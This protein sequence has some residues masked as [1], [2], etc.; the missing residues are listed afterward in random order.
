LFFRRWTRSHFACFD[1]LK[2]HARKPRLTGIV[3]AVNGAEIEKLVA[4]CVAL[5]GLR[6]RGLDRERQLATPISLG[7]WLMRRGFSA[8][9]VLAE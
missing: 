3:F 9:I 2:K 8:V 1:S 7:P 6:E 5:A 4:E